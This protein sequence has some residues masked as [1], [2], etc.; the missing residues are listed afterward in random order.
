MRAAFGLPAKY[1]SVLKWAEAKTDKGEN[2]MSDQDSQMADATELG[3]LGQLLYGLMT[4]QA[5]HVAAKLGI[6]DLVG[7]APETVE[8]LAKAT[9]TDTASLQR[10]LRMLTSV[11]VFAEEANGRSRQTRLSGLLRSDHPRSEINNH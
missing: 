4:S 5:I 11:G 8:E 1:S 3:Q 7:E 2:T 6:A 9:R 10:V